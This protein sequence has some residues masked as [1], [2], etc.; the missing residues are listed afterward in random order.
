MSEYFVFD[1]FRGVIYNMWQVIFET[2]HC[3][4]MFTFE[5]MYIFY[6]PSVIIVHVYTLNNCPV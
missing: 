1:Y 2:F 5:S 6:F 3:K 4:F